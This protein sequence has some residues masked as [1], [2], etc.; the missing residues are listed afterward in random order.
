MFQK[1]SLPLLVT[2]FIPPSLWPPNSPDVNPVDYAVWWILQERVYKHYQIT[3][4]EELRQ[5]VEEEWDSLDQDVIWQR[6]QWMAQATDSLYY[7]PQ[8][9]FWTFSLNITTFVHILINMF[10]T[11]LTLLSVKQINFSCTSNSDYR[12]FSNFAR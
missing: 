4:V 3:D 5:R 2:F 8:R 12:E 6:D 10:W 7:S 9:T 11:L 1:Q